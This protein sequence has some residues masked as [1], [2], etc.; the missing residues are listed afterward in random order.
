MFM[1]VVLGGRH[2]LVSRA[3]GGWDEK[4]VLL[5]GGWVFG[6]PVMMMWYNKHLGP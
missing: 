6:C 3:V 5:S 2:H 4:M 1:Y